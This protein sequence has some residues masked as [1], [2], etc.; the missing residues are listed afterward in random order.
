MHLRNENMHIYVT[1][2]YSE[3]MGTKRFQQKGFMV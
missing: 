3:K 2:V 1:K